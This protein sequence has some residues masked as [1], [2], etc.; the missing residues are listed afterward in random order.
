[1][2]VERGDM[3]EGSENTSERMQDRE[4]LKPDAIRTQHFVW[5]MMLLIILGRLSKR[6]FTMRK[7][8]RS[9]RYSVQVYL[10]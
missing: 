2:Y 6:F 4:K 10:L 7:H 9:H 5:L 1:M 3:D 8:L